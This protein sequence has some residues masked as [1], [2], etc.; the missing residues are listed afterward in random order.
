M[1]LVCASES[2]VGSTI[3]VNCGSIEIIRKWMLNSVDCGECNLRVLRVFIAACPGLVDIQDSARPAEVEC[4]LCGGAVRNSAVVGK[5]TVEE[6]TQLVASGAA[7]GFVL[8][9]R[10]GKVEIDISPRVLVRRCRENIARVVI[11]VLNLPCE[12]AERRSL[13]PRVAIAGLKAYW[14][15]NCQR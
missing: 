14:R 11:E 10:V 15:S 4:G 7:N 5:S 1:S 6:V 3:G 13:A 2:Q 9:S 8:E 12:V